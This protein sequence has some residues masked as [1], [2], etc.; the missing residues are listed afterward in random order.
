MKNKK[1]QLKFFS[2]ASRKYPFTDCFWHANT[3]VE[4]YIMTK[5]KFGWKTT[6]KEIFKHLGKSFDI[7]SVLNY[8]PQFLFSV[9]LS[10]LLC[11]K[12][13][14]NAIIFNQ[15]H[16]KYNLLS[17]VLQFILCLKIFFFSEAQ[18]E[19]KKMYV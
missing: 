12:C 19:R 14:Q 18:K 7:L 10:F 17:H 11:Y 1:S 5:N 8:L 13:N 2:I 15:N 4:N 6:Q 9:N 3:K 16:I